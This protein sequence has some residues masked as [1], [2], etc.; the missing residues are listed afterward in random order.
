MESPVQVCKIN[1]ESLIV[2][3]SHD[4]R[5]NII[6]QEKKFEFSFEVYDGIDELDADD[7]QLLIEARNV[8]GQAYAPYSNFHVGAAAKLSNNK[9][10]TGTN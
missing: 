10:V 4:L 3:D 9:I 6:M 1:R 2:C 7:R 5:Q 8:T